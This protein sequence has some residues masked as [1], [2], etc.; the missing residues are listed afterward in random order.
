MNEAVSEGS[1]R[2]PRVAEACVSG[3][4]ASTRNERCPQGA[5]LLEAV[6]DGE[7][8]R[9]AYARVMANKG[10]AGVDGMPVEAL[11]GRLQAHWSKLKEDLLAGRYR[12]QAVLGAQIPKPGGGVRQ[13][14]IPTVV[15]RLIQQ[16]LH[17]VLC[18]IFDPDF[19]ENSY[20]FRPG[21]SAH[22]A[23]IRAREHVAQGRRWVVD[24]DLE[25]FLEA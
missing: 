8:M 4:T 19:S 9:A 12:P 20:G 15:D 22:Q 6:L 7:N 25:K 18:P 24:M 1:G 3:V 21:R 2:N 17:Q 16:A 14:G 5:G 13:L 23:V 11:K 10:V